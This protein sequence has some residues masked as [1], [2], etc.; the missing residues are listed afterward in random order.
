MEE[1]QQGKIKSLLYF[2][3]IPLLFLAIF[4]LFIF[5]WLGFP[6]WKS[7]QEWGNNT[8]VISMIMPDPVSEESKKTSPSDD[9]KA[10][11]LDSDQKVK[12]EAQ[13]IAS[14][15]KQI[16]SN[17]EE[18]DQLKK[19]NIDLQNQ[20]DQKA[21]QKN[22]DQLKQVAAIYENMAPSKAAKMFEV[23][24]L[25]DAAITMSSLGQEQQSNILGSMKDPKKAAQI[26]MLLKE[27]GTIND[28]DPAI[29]KDELQKIVQNDVD[30]A[31]SLVET[32]AGMPAAQSASLIQ[33]MMESNAQVAMNLLKQMSTTNRSQILT[34]I[35]KKD[36]KI[37]AQITVNL[38]K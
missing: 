5:N 4:G 8:P 34:E 35:A 23:M 7:I 32:I 30:P 22:K 28:T 1:K 29:L 36:A 14:L 37:A 16:K 15:E 20:L 2:G 18:F 21:T 33:S 3:L 10:K 6:V 11:Y 19:S 26:T 9:Y 38:E 27:I 17:Q 13:K 24:S 12:E 25:E 31:G